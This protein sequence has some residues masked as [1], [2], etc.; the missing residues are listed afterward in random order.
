MWDFGLS[1]TMMFL[2]AHSGTAS[3]WRDPRGWAVAQLAALCGEPV[4]E[5]TGIAATDWL[6]DEYAHGSYAHIR[7][8][9]DD[10]DIDEL[11]APAG[12]VLFAGEHTS[13]TRL[14]YADGA[15]SSGLREAKRLLQ[16]PRATL[17]MR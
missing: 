4:P 16:E 5:P 11:A 10:A 8:G 2:V 7:P 9:E 3:A 12:R 1:P 15:M 6:H 13:R 17:S 14:G